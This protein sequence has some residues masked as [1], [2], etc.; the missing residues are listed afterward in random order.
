MEP[1]ALEQFAIA[2]LFGDADSFASAVRDGLASA[3]VTERT[4]TGVGFFATIRFLRPLPAESSQSQ[5]DWN[6]LHRAL[7]H[8][9]S[10][11]AWREGPDGI[12]L[13][14]VS[15]HGNWPKDFDP[16]DFSERP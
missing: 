2:K 3:T 4:W 5:W 1:N 12:G 14:G 10:F 16:A 7:T 6:F 9:G 13:E 8:G 11:I 15:H